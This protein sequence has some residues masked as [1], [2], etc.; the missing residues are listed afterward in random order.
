MHRA[1]GQQRPPVVPD[2][3]S[4]LFQ[5]LTLLGLAPDLQVQGV[6][7]A[8]WPAAQDSL[9]WP[10]PMRSVAGVSLILIEEV[11]GRAQSPWRRLLGRRL[12]G[13]AP[14]RARCCLGNLRA[15]FPPEVLA[16]A[17]VEEPGAV[18]L[19][20]PSL[21]LAQALRDLQQV[22]RS[23]L[24]GSPIL[25]LSPSV[26]YLGVSLLGVSMDFSKIQRKCCGY[27]R[28]PRSLRTRSQQS[29]RISPIITHC[30]CGV[31]ESQISQCLSLCSLGGYLRMSLSRDLL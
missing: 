3:R 11:H 18:R 19:A 14:G 2:Q 28:E 21:A 25:L 16:R 31:S 1:A 24:R 27:L 4:P 7:R 6:R 17:G 10:S 9:L 12:P 29:W 26:R 5:R 20:R 30:Q 23:P 22:P 8:R 15:V 13:L